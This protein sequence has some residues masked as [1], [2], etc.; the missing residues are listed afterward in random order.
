M[1]IPGVR[2]PIGWW[3]G[4]GI[5]VVAGCRDPEPRW[6]VDRGPYRPWREAQE[7]RR[8]VRARVSL[9]T[10]FAELA[11]ELRPA[12]VNLYAEV[13]VDRDGEVQADPEGNPSVD[14]R[15]PGPGARIRT[16][17][18]GAIVSPSGHILTSRHVVA[19]ARSIQVRL[20]DGREFAATLAGEDER[21]DLAL[22]KVESEE[23][24]PSV[25]FGDSESL[26]VGQWLLVVGNPFGL[27][28]TVSVGILSARDRN[29]GNG[30]FDD[31]V[32]LD[33]SINPGNSGGPVFDT[34]GKMVAVAR[35]SRR[36]A[37]GIGF[38]VPVN[39]A[40]EFIEEVLSGGAVVRGWMGVAVQEVRPGEWDRLAVA[41]GPGVR[42]VRVVEDSPAARAGL[43][44]DDVIRAVA[45]RPVS[46]RSDFRKVMAMT[47]A[48]ETVELLVS[49]RGR[50]GGV[51]V[52]LAARP[53]LPPAEPDPPG[54][55]P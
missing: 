7:G 39:V 51:P 6:V 44:E 15:V 4:I 20:L 48:G 49:R 50:E 52:V 5:L 36:G 18:S 24:L 26:R 21:Y 42:V 31:F 47:R 9:E 45:G 8:P 3:L 1:K 34:D 19:G 53:R 35:L 11:E 22:L 23:P 14:P 55:V 25:V 13:P 27:E 29:I 46:S 43:S 54:G 38:A 28:H 32:Q 10:G 2:G 17:G 33:A 30:P 12:V 16:L 40:K 41:P 37:Q